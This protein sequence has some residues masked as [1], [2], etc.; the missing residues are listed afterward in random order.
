LA[1]ALLG[2]AESFAILGASTVTNIGPSTVHGDLG[3]SPSASITGF[4][5]A[6]TIVGTGT[7]TNGPGLVQGTI[8]A[9]HPTALQAQA[10]SLIAYNVLKDLPCKSNI[11]G[12]GLGGLI[13]TP[14]VYCFDTSAG[15]T[16]T[17]TLNA[18]N[19]PDALFVFQIGSEL[20]TEIGSVV[21]VLNG[22]ANG[23]VNGG[24]FWEVGSSA[25]LGA[26]TSFAGNILALASVT[27]NTTASIL[28]GRAIALNG[29]VTMATNTISNDCTGAGDFDSG[30][31]DYGSVGFGGGFESFPDANAPGGIGFRP[32]AG[33]G[34]DVPEP[35]TLA[36]FSFGLAGLTGFARRRKPSAFPGITSSA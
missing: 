27:L 16:G 36:L 9:Q 30:R 22:G 35:A 29:A 12:T 23:A 24:V 28:C 11:S 34:A 32:I 2:D 13:L 10:A 18:L 3:L 19:N 4:L 7:V 26:S 33:S 17:L 8:Y 15:L 21:S 25:T 14:G 1:G 5:P 6:N 20:T 31:S